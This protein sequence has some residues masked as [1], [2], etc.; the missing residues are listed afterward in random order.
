MRLAIQHET[1][2]EYSVPLR[3]TT[4][5]LRLTPRASPHQTVLQW[6]LQAPGPLFAQRDA[7]GN[8]GHTWTL[9]RQLRRGAIRAAGIV[10]THDSPWLVDEPALPS[11][12][13]YLRPTP[14]A[15]AH[16]ALAA[17][18]AAALAGGADE[19]RLLAFADAVLARVPWRAG[20]T[21]VRTTA[22][23]A[24]ALGAGVCQDHAHVFIAA[25]R[26]H[27]LPARY[28]SGYFYAP[29]APA[30][31]SHAWVDVC[32]DVH[33][34]RWLSVDVTHRCLMDERHVRLAVGPDYAACLPIRGVRHGGG[35]EA[36]RVRVDI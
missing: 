18:G 14:L 22:V 19:A 15:P 32:L 3:Y 29:D 9:A 12:L 6:A 5:W 20:T 21:D 24:L 33:A 4:Q 17:L 13:V 28:V 1:H 16:P 27:G 35:R 26:A 10:Q 11:P 31:A 34:R 25:C 2:Y 30:L 23:E 7:Y 8:D 36:M